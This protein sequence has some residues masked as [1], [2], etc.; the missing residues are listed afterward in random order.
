MQACV[1]SMASRVLL[2][3]LAGCS[4]SAPPPRHLVIV[5]LDTLR[6]DR[7]GCYGNDR[8]LTPN[9][10]AVAA[11]G[12][13]ISDATASV[14]CTSPSHTTL[15]TGQH[16]LSHGLVD[17]FHELNDSVDTLA[18]ALAEQGFATA[19]YFH[20]YQF[21]Q[22]RITQG[23]ERVFQDQDPVAAQVVPELAAW[24]ARGR[25]QEQRL[26]LWVHL[27]LP[28]APADAPPAFR[29]R[30]LAQPY[31][32]PLDQEVAT[33][34][35]IRRGVIQ[36][37]QEYLRHFRDCYDA[38]VALTDQRVGELLAV[39]RRAGIL[40]ES[41]LLI[42]ADHGESLEQG[43]IGLHSP[44]LRQ[45]TLHVPLLITARALP[46]GRRV[47]AIVGL[48]DVAPTVL[49][50]LGVLPTMPFQGRSRWPLLEGAVPAEEGTVFSMLPS[51]YLGRRLPGFPE[52][53]PAIAA[54]R[55]RF[56]LV[57]SPDQIEL[58]DLER[59]PEEQVDVAPEHPEI[60][61]ALRQALEDHVRQ[62]T[63]PQPGQAPLDERAMEQMRALGYVLE[64]G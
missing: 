11:R 64:G 30:F 15:F 56:K 54:R 31:D 40:E 6:A 57:K 24:L 16:P 4:D 32:G 28:H 22:A 2:L 8:G 46:A 9:L 51:E 52:D 37:P 50:G 13:L 20:R 36:P 23:F 38:D 43:V 62:T 59:D 10:D 5:T 34:E 48:V 49:E 3:A 33:L 1:R 61:A 53:P 42:T 21:D 44:V 55:G 7:L 45:S 35:R 14:P 58:F 19:A 63:L 29:E 60:V 25:W 41:L 39:L 18:E 27:Y 17:N 47:E 26:F 12:V